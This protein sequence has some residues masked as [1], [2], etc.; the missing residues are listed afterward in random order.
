MSA[1]V[2]GLFVFAAALLCV[3][4]RLL[5]M[6]LE[7]LSML[8]ALAVFCGARVRPVWL[9]VLAVLGTRLVSDAALHWRTGYGFYGSMAFDYAAYLFVLL[10]GYCLRPRTTSRALAAGLVSAVLFFLI[11]NT[12]AWCMPLNGQYLYPQTAQGLLQ[13]LANG[14]PF[15][16]GTLAGDLLLTPLLFHVAGLLL[17]S[18]PQSA[19][20]GSKHAAS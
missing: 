3:V 4:L 15:A 19:V 16:R 8:G 10:A 5:P 18:R 2:T 9:A 6:P 14:L 1:K 7:N 11:S 17:V 13:C 20:V 12:G